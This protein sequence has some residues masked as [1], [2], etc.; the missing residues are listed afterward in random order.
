MQEEA[1][2]VWNSLDVE[3]PMDG[4]TAVLVSHAICSEPALAIAGRDQDG[5]LAFVDGRRLVVGSPCA[6]ANTPQLPSWSRKG[7]QGS[8]G[9]KGL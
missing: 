4:H 5:K 1:K 3:P 7:S 9:S 8:V 2:I 6:W